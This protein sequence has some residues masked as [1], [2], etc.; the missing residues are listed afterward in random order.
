[1]SDDATPPDEAAD[2]ESSDA[3]VDA[4]PEPERRHGAIVTEQLGDTV[5]HCDADGYLE[6]ATALRDE[7]FTQLTDLTAVDYLTHPGRHVPAP[8]IA[9]RFEVVAA[10][11]N[12]RTR[13][14]IRI[15]VQVAADEPVVASLFDLWPGSEALEREVFDMYGIHFEGHPDM[16]RILMP[17]E[18]QGH[19]LRK[20]YG[21]GAIPVQFKAASNIR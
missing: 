4:A 8:L 6:L 16:T 20:D 1:V 7:G 5:L 21:I 13:E 14:R 11:R 12:H 19:P 15:R 9:E 10:V 18:W 2:D 3:E 17:E